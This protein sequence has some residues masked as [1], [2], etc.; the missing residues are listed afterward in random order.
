MADRRG[1]YQ[2][3]QQAGERRRQESRRAR[4]GNWVR[5]L[6]I[7]GGVVA[8]IGLVI[9]GIF[10]FAGTQKNLPPTSFGPGHIEEFPPQQINTVPILRSIQEHVMERGGGHHQV[11]SMLVQYNCD[12]YQC[13]QN[14][15]Q[16]LVEL[17]GD[18]PSYVYL[19]PFPGMDAMIALAAPGR[20]ETLDNF[21]EQ[22]IRQFIV[23][24][25]D[26]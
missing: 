6:L 3:R 18:Y 16:M 2:R 1:R 14:L 22:A 24:N 20:L 26:R 9:G 19:A 10:Q 25:L 4:R 23:R 17:V 21:D 8:T 12:D 7:F 11:G 15:V 5:T 13:E